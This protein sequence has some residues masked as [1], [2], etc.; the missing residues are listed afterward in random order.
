MTSPN[1]S[2]RARF[3][4]PLAATIASRIAPTRSGL[5]DVPAP[6]VGNSANCTSFWRAKISW[7]N[8]SA[9]ERPAASSQTKRTYA[10]PRSVRA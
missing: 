9:R 5:A 4:A 7:S 1:G 8:G 10:L 3:G 6:S 2:A